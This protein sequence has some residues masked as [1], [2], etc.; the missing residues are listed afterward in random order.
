MPPWATGMFSF[1]DD[2]AAL[3]PVAPTTALITEPELPRYDGTRPPVQIKKINVEMPEKNR[4]AARRVNTCLIGTCVVFA[5]C[6]H[7]IP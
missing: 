5:Y 4:D 7:R 6:L 1:I 2:V 3:Y